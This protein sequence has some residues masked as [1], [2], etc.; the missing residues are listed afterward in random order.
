MATRKPVTLHRLRDMHAQGE[1]ITMLT[2]YDATFAHVLDRAGVDV[3]LV[4][5]SLGTVLQGLETT[6]PVSIDEMVYHT[7]CVAR[8]NRCAWLIADLP[9]GSYQETPQLALR[10]AVRLMQAGAQMVKLEGGGWTAPVVQFLVERD[11]PVCAH[12]GFTPQSVH[13]LGG[14]RVQGRNA[15]DAEQLRRQADELVAAGAAMLVLEMVPAS[16][17]RELTKQLSIPVIGIGAGVGCSGQVLVLHD[18]LGLTRSTPPR[19]VRNFLEPGA[20]IEG[21]VQRYIDDVKEGRFPDDAQ[22][23]F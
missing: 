11:I 12:L 18:M 8:G 23:G 15:S 21:A 4:G 19:F 1:K 22:H 20:T 16:L 2:C 7:R 13:A 9:F 14:Y 10:N 5:D 6:L 17:A 3:L